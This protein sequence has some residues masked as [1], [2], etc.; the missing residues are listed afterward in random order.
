MLENSVTTTETFLY[1]QFKVMD[2]LMR[3]DITFSLKNLRHTFILLTR[4]DVFIRVFICT[5]GLCE[6]NA[7]YDIRINMGR[8]FIPSPYRF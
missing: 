5:L 1:H 8:V 7:A 4:V 6:N 3:L 2:L